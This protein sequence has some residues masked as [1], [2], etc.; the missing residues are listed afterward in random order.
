ML[1]GWWLGP[2]P[3]A[4]KLEGG[5]QNGACQRQCPCGRM[6]PPNGCCQHLFPHCES[7]LLP[8]SPGGSASLTSGSDPGS[9]HITASALGARACEIL[10]APFKSGVS[11]S[12]SPLAFPKLIPT[13]LQSQMFCGLIFQV[14]DPWTWEPDAGLRSLTPWREPLQL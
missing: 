1:T 14:Q 5:F 9:F 3:G 13:G 6:S 8:P 11:V 2:G 4:N 12:H 10:C 7:Q